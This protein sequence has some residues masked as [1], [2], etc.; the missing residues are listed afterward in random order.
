MTRLSLHLRFISSF[1]RVALSV[2]QA[3]CTHCTTMRRTEITKR[4]GWIGICRSVFCF[5]SWLIWWCCDSQRQWSWWWW[6]EHYG[7]I[8]RNV[9]CL[10]LC[11]FLNGFSFLRNSHLIIIIMDIYI[12]IMLTL[13][14]RIIFHEVFSSRISFLMRWRNHQIDR[15]Q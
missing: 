1:F 10:R 3:N 8:F 12:Y 14:S 7:F 9:M 5:L 4:N 15:W 6:N 13:F 11:D 2:F